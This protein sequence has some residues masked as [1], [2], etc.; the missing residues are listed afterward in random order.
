M[1][2]RA[3]PPPWSA[4]DGDGDTDVNPKGREM[5]ETQITETIKLLEENG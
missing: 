2:K 1:H 5:P 4:P 3:G